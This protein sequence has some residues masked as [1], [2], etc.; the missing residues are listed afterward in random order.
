[1]SDGNGV[2]LR[3][4]DTTLAAGYRAPAAGS[5]LISDIVA[6]PSG[7]DVD[8]EIM[9][10]TPSKYTISRSDTGYALALVPTRRTRHG[11]CPR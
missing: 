11:G 6:S 4:L 7:S 3:F 1:M 9:L 5:G 10:G 2:L 8:V